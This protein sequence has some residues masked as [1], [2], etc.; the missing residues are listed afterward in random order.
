MAGS[1]EKTIAVARR[2]GLA[3][4]MKGGHEAAQLLTPRGE[5]HGGPV[6]EGRRPGFQI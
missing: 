1:H 3:D 4:K 6:P 2:K 5:E